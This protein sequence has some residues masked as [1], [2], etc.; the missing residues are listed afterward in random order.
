MFKGIPKPIPQ[1]N[2]AQEGKAKS[3]SVRATKEDKRAKLPSP[4]K[5]LDGKKEK[6]KGERCLS[7]G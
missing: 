3:T 2:V 1:V 5:V 7:A 4:A 6:R